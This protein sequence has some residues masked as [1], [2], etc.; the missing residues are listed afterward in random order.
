MPPDPGEFVG[1]S[2]VAQILQD[3]R[4][5][6]DTVIVDAPPLLHVGDALTLGSHVDAFIV[7]VQ[8]RGA[9]VATLR[10]LRRVLDTCRAPTLGLVL[11]GTDTKAEYGGGYDYQ[12]S[13]RREHE[14][15]R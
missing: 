3:L 6:F 5:R 8:Y 7:V 1:T 14:Q 12:P 4:D 9:R 2:A 13:V 15:I 10:E 11:T